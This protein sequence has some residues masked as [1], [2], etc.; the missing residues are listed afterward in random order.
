MHLKLIKTEAE[1]D[2]VLS[3]VA[4]LMASEPGTPEFEELEVLSVLIEVY[5]RAHHPIDPPDPIDAILFRMEQAGLR[6]RNLVPFFGNESK[7]SEVLS[8][9]RQLSLNMIRALHEGLDIPLAVLV[10]KPRARTHSA[11]KSAT[12]T[13]PPRADARRSRN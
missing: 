10:Q 12:H 5:E 2:A 7:V 1:L 6:R 8:G 11:A 4:S 9:T 13:R 3:R